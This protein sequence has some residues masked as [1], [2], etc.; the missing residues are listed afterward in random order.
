MSNIRAIRKMQQLNNLV[1]MV[2]DLARPG[3]TIVDFCSGTVPVITRRSGVAHFTLCC[4]RAQ[5]R[6]IA[7]PLVIGWNE[8][9]PFILS[10]FF[11]LTL[12]AFCSAV[13]RPCTQADWSLYSWEGCVAGRTLEAIDTTVPGLSFDVA[14]LC[15]VILLS[16]CSVSQGH[17]G[18]VLAHTFPDCQVS[19]L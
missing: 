4:I 11:L 18:I 3:D 16:N 15:I 8:A 14:L 10:H 5:L 9:R 7:A 2:T 6:Q 13:T 17:V 19:L 1:A 12:N